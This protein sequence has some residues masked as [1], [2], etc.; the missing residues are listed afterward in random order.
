MALKE[1]LSK[2]KLRI[3][4]TA[5]QLFK[6]K[7]Y[8]ASSM[9]ELAERVDLKVSSL[10]SHIGSKEEI[11]QKIC[12]DNA[13]LF[14]EGI[15]IIEEQTSNP[16]EKLEAL[17]ALH[18]D[19]AIDSPSSITVFND[20]WKNLSREGSMGL[21]SFLALRKDYENRFRK[22]IEIGSQQAFFKT[23]DAEVALYTILAALQWLHYWNRPAKTTR[24]QVLKQQIQ[25]LLLG[26]LAQ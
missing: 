5:A 17:I 15:S 26:G 1:R 6:E 22:I 24:R 14:L 18:V 21:K 25:T 3:Y 9:R 7:G 2:Q 4:E 20:E 12:F 8:K 16:R 13:Q 11:L 19:I 10:Y 23:L